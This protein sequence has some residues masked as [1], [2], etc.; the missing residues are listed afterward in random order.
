MY[1]AVILYCTV[2]IDVSTCDV[3]I[4]R[5]HLFEDKT[6]CK[7]QINTMARGLISTGHTVRSKCFKFN[8][9]GEET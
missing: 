4:R 5:D 7:L 2:A 3:M 1:L 6:E 8:P 9:Y